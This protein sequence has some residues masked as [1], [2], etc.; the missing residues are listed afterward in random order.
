M[1]FLQPNWLYILSIYTNNKL[2]FHELI[3]KF[4]IFNMK[5]MSVHFY[6]CTYIIL[7][8][9][10]YKRITM[11]EFGSRNNRVNLSFENDLFAK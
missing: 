8:R 4:T 7:L 9:L 1:H 5:F 11:L 6:T 10:I 3:Y 2:I